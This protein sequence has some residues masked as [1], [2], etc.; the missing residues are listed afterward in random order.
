MLQFS[1]DRSFVDLSPR[2]KCFEMQYFVNIN[3][4]DKFTA[5]INV[6][7]QNIIYDKKSWCLFL[8]KIN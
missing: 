6:V 3:E 7:D 1:K 2:L 8:I 5:W 4:N